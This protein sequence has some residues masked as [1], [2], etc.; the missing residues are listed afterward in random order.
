MTNPV[1]TETLYK[2]YLELADILPPEVVSV[3]EIELR[4]TLDAYGVALMMIANG[5]SHP[6]S[7]AIETLER[8]KSLA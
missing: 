1:Y 2:L 6:G 4:K 3:R 8:H 7:L 5:C